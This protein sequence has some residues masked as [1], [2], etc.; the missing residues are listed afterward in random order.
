MLV[1]LFVSVTRGLWTLRI[2]QSLV[3]TVEMS[4]SDVILV[5]NFNPY[6]LVFERAAALHKAD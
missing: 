1:M 4:P 5:E 3:C 6:Y 2:G